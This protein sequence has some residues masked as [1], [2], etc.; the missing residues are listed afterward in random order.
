MKSGYIYVLVHPSDPDLY[1][2]GQTTH[3]PEKRLAEH[4]SN[5]EEYAGQ[6]VKET[7]QKWE[8][9]EYHAVPDPCW[10]ETVFWRATPLAD[11]PFRQGIEVEKMEWEWVQKGLDAAKK[12]GVRRPPPEPLPDYV[13]AYTAWMNKR[14]E[15]RDITLVGYV[16]SMV[17]GKATFRCS[18]G[19]EWRTRSADVAEGKGCPQCGI[20]DR[21]PDEIWQAAKLGYLCLLIHPDKP[22]VIKIGLTY[23]T[24]EQCY[25]ENVWGDWE[26]HRYRF[27]EEPVLAETLI[28]ELLGQPLPN[29]REPIEID[30]S[31]AE[32]AFRD[33]IYKMHREIALAEKKKE[34]AHKTD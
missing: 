33:L 4:N 27:V 15:G 18:N 29:D 17:S 7:G 24:L 21:E 23:S 1:K 22:G 6:I 20:G 11:I 30:L 19:H 14:L 3:H 12:A 8:L 2:V 28:W 13:Y 10:A 25:E 32:Q 34:D 5:Y 31:V 9:K 16:K 26:V